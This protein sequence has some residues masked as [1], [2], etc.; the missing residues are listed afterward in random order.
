MN[1]YICIYIY[2][3]YIL[4]VISLVTDIK[5]IPLEKYTF[6]TWRITY[7]KPVKPLNWRLMR[8]LA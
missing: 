1:I 6:D 4:N 8:G 2:Y 7:F 3:I 5:Y